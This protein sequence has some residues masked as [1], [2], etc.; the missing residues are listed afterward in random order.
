MDP[1]LTQLQSS[2]SGPSVDNNCTGGFLH[3][4]DIRT[5]ATSEESLVALP[6]V[7]LVKQFTERNF[8]KLNMSKYKI[9]VFIKSQKVAFLDCEVDGSVLPAGDVGKC[10]GYWWKADLLAT[11][12]VEDN[13]QKAR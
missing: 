3:A 9:M 10:L 2:G 13:I 12:S 6:Q 7:E 4:D 5:L 11:R 8:L 1:L